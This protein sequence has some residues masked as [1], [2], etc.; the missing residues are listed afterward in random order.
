[1]WLRHAFAICAMVT[2]SATALPSQASPAVGPS[3]ND[4]RKAGALSQLSAGASIR[5][6]TRSGTFNGRYGRLEN[7]SVLLQSGVADGARIPLLEIDT[8]WIRGRNHAKG[9][10]GGALIGSV[11]GAAAVGSL[12][13]S[14]TRTTGDA[15]NCGDTIAAAIAWSALLGGA[16]G[17]VVGWPSWRQVW[18]Q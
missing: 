9:I 2:L 11:L 5:V 13:A 1:M 18:P 15:C 3:S 16:V 4:V 10:V 14:I 6:A 17:A 12:A 7:Q 8:L